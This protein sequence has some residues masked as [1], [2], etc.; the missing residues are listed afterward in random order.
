M[1]IKR[2]PSKTLLRVERTGKAC[3]RAWNERTEDGRIRYAIAGLGLGLIAGSLLSA[4]AN[5]LG[6]IDW[7]SFGPAPITFLG[8]IVGLCLFVAA[9]MPE[10]WTDES[11]AWERRKLDQKILDRARDD[12]EFREELK[13]NPR[14][15]IERE[16]PVRLRD[17]HEITVLEERPKH[18]YIV[19]PVR[20]SK[21]L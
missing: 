18:A 19:L 21:R 7:E 15:A 17:G 10:S 13:I 16:F 3:V 11:W 5:S 14:Q 4:V 9:L 12:P 6:L 8:C 2:A 20:Q 1:D